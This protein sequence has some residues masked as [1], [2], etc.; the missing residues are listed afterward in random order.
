MSSENI[1]VGVRIRPLLSSEQEMV[2]TLKVLPDQILLF[3]PQTLRKTGKKKPEARYCF[4]RL[5]DKHC[6]QQQ[7]FE[8]T[9]KPLVQHVLDGYNAT[10]FAYGATG[11]GKTFTISGSEQD[12]G[13]ITRT[14][15]HLFAS[16]S[17]LKEKVE[18]KFS[19]LEIYNETIRDLITNQQGL[20]LREDDKQVIVAGLSEH[21]PKDPKQVMRLITKG[22]EN[23]S[24]AFTMANATSSRSHAVLQ[25]HC[26][27]F[28]QQGTKQ[29]VLQGVLSII[30]LAGSER[31]SATQ[32]TGDRLLEGANINRSLLSLGN[33][34][35]ALCSDKPTHVPYRDSKLTR[36]LKYSL[37]GSCKVVMI[38]NVSPAPIHSDE[39]HNTLKYA[40]RAKDIQTK[41]SQNTVDVDV[42]LS[43]YPE[44][45][46]SLRKELEDIK[47]NQITEEDFNSLL[48]RADKIQT[49][50]QNKEL[51]LCKIHAT[52]ES[53]QDQ[54]DFLSSLLDLDAVQ[55]SFEI[56]GPKIQSRIEELGAS[57]SVL[58]HN[59]TTLERELETQHEKLSQLEQKVKN[60]LQ[61]TR[62][63]M[64]LSMHTIQRQTRIMNLQKQQQKDLIKNQ[65]QMLSSAANLLFSQRD[66]SLLNRF[67]RPEEVDVL[68]ETDDESICS[69]DEPETPKQAVLDDDVLGVQGGDT[70][71]PGSLETPKARR[72]HERQPSDDATPKNVKHMKP[73]LRRGPR[74]SMI[75]I[76]SQR[77]LTPE[78][79]QRPVPATE[80]KK[81]KENVP[82]RH[83]MSLRKRG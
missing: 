81:K 9:A 30:D 45:I 61:R 41:V 6:T 17:K 67:I 26:K 13:I 3:E 23:R 77:L 35:N 12:P 19:Y 57:H 14:L 68:Y 72:V 69:I 2:P 51:E 65:H 79:P 78:K 20:D 33:C 63:A 7:V 56:V 83:T 36:L 50:I 49:R 11:C 75:P 52:L 54:M 4:D 28:F 10:C 76:H 44:I 22:N 47:A 5:F 32:N 38:A 1:L 15:E 34:I 8:Q 71:T 24:K 40:N 27:R 29:R 66:F 46:A 31:A 21:A 58:V 48:G 55:R 18:I 73:L 25:I 42:H 64:A 70:E 80:R 37:S 39:T 74:Q 43:K 16:V 62:L 53:Y 60:P 82:P 59:K